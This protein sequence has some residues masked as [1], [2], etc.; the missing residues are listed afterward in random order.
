MNDNFIDEEQNLSSVAQEGSVVKYNTSILKQPRMNSREA[1]LFLIVVCA[2]AIVLALIFT[3]SFVEKFF[4]EPARES[5]L[6][7]NTL[8][9]EVDYQMPILNLYTGLDPAAVR[10]SFASAGYESID[11]TDEVTLAEGSGYD[12]VKNSVECDLELTR[13]FFTEN[14]ENLSPSECAMV[15]NGSW[16]LDSDSPT[17]NTV[18]LRYADVE[19]E[20][21]DAAIAKAISYQGLETAEVLE[22]GVDN[23]GNTFKAGKVL[24][25]GTEYLWRV[26]AYN[27]NGVYDIQGLPENSYYVGTR[28][29]L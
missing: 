17:G 20:T 12:L 23:T 1:R 2:V 3:L 27:L 19:S 22:F 28:F 26:S 16:R 4:K 5:Q 29:T 10:E 15:I 13:K 8:E 21:I 9:K 18:R 14:D 11:L 25:D 24:I 6:F 7:L